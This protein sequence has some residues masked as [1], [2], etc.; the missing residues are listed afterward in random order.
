MALP[1]I[2]LNLPPGGVPGLNTPALPSNPPSSA[3][4]KA[5]VHFKASVVRELM[6]L[7][8]STISDAA[9]EATALY[10]SDILNARQ[11]GLLLAAAPPAPGPVPAVPAAP[12]AGVA[13][14][15]AAVNALGGRLDGRLDSIDRQLAINS[16]LAKGTGCAIPYAEVAFLD[17]S[18]PSVAVLGPLARPALPLLDNV[19]KIKA[20]TGPQ[21]TLYLAG[22]GFVGIIPLPVI[23]RRRQIAQYVGCLVQF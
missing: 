12:M 21:C 15:L 8:Q 18:R 23:N 19:N 3:D 10:E 2:T 7:P 11:M 20:L 17:G 22:Y 14:V 16:N 4:V 5:A 1:Q 13:L 6:L 9:I